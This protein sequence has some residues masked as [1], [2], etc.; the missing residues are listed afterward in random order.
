MSANAPKKPKN[1]LLTDDLIASFPAPDPSGRQ[2]IYW[3]REV[4]GLGLQCS[5]SS[6]LKVW[7]VQ[8][9]NKRRTIERLQF[10]PLAEARRAAFDWLKA[11][12]D[13][14]P[15]PRAL[16]RTA[17]E[18]TA[19][20]PTAP[21]GPTL[22]MVFDSYLKTKTLRLQSQQFYQSIFSNHLAVW[23]NKPVT[24]IDAPMIAERHRQI[25]ARVSRKR[26]SGGGSTA[27]GMARLLSGLL[28]YAGEHLGVPVVAKVKKA[29]KGAW[30]KEPKRRGLVPLASMPAF[31][32]TLRKLP[33]E[34]RR[35]AITLLLFTG[36]RLREV[37]AL[38]W[39]EVRLDDRLIVLPEER[40]KAKRE[41]LIP[42]SDPCVE[43]LRR[44]V[45][46]RRARCDFV[47]HGRNNRPIRDLANEFATLSKAAGVHLIP[48]DLRRT[49]AT[50]AHAAGLDGLT[51]GRLINHST[52]GGLIGDQGSPITAGYIIRDDN[53]LRAAQQKITDFILTAAKVEPKPRR[54]LKRHSIREAATA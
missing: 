24:E 30:A 17:Q 16:A 45:S 3:D 14:T 1:Y 7:V 54:M 22:Q 23:A 18:S 49:Y 43:I 42:L 6:R 2:V 10:M 27:N 36:C 29:L 8:H 31:Y 51:I 53:Q 34:F 39:S 50:Y 47:F 44:M 35:D 12:H 28:E 46:K 52:N 5:G 25:I 32:G 9:R 26:G 37:T 4:T 13:G 33:D 38:R 19:P 21:Q 11:L 15:D 40:T 41:H 20:Q 48:H